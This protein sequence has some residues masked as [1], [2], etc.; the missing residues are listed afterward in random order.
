MSARSLPFWSLKPKAYS[1]AERKA[2]MATRLIVAE[3]GGKMR[4]G[5]QP[6]QLSGLSMARGRLRR[7]R[8]RAQSFLRPARKKQASRSSWSPTG[9]TPSYSTKNLA[10]FRDGFRVLFAGF[11][12]PPSLSIRD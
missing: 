1:D 7:L 10:E 12:F 9:S 2:E 11:P 5:L 8:G 3:S 4:V 6:A